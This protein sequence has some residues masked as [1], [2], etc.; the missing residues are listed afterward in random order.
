M[1]D[2]AMATTVR[3]PNFLPSTSGLKFANSWPHEADLTLRLQGRFIF[4]IGDAANGLCGGMAFETADHHI[5]GVPIWPETE[6]PPADSPRF[7]AIVSR[8]LDSLDWGILPLR[9]YSMMAFRP[10][11]ATVL[12]NLLGR[13]PQTTATVRDE[14]PKIRAGL[15]AGSLVN[16]GLVRA[17]ANDPR[18]LT[19][20]HQVL[21]Y[22]YTLDTGSVAIALYDPNHPADDTVELRVE[23]DA[24]GRVSRLEQSTGEPLFAFFQYPYSAKPPTD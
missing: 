1:H 5:A 2:A 24:D 22:G 7:K 10:G 15:D 18:R 4:G 12:G 17:S 6:A 16:I 8:Q 13:A 3:V 9:F 20:N 11:V 14:W 23:L 19:A 21:A